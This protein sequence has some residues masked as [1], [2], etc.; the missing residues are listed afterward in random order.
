MSIN[1]G[2]RM[3]KW[4]IVLVIGMLSSVLVVMPM[5]NPYQPT[6]EYELITDVSDIKNKAEKIVFEFWNKPNT[7]KPFF[8]RIGDHDGWFGDGEWIEVGLD[9]RV[10][11]EK[12]V[13]KLAI[14]DQSEPG[15]ASAED[16]DMYLF[17]KVNKVYV[18]MHKNTSNEIEFGPQTGA[19]R[20]FGQKVKGAQYIPGAGYFQATES[21][22]PLQDNI[23]KKDI[24]F[25]PYIHALWG[26]DVSPFLVKIRKF[27]Y[28]LGRNVVDDILNN[29]DYTKIAAKV[30]SRRGNFLKLEQFNFIQT[31]LT[32][33]LEKIDI[34]THIFGLNDLRQIAFEFNNRQGW[35]L[36]HEI[37][38]WKAV[39]PVNYVLFGGG[40]SS[41]QEEPKNKV[42]LT[43]KEILLIVIS[44]IF[45]SLKLSIPN[46]VRKEELYL[47]DM[48]G[49]IPGWEMVTR[50]NM[51]NIVSAELDSFF[52]SDEYWDTVATWQDDQ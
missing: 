11:S 51:L 48:W 44:R 21:K 17:G 41:E 46:S 25:L 8:I 23:T 32:N 27:I 12:P 19:T 24:V 30:A 15:A 36:L 13:T 52:S 34:D 1:G 18:R 49:Q 6:E 28:T 14:T 40:V 16:V 22:L 39:K 2:R 7:E 3:K 20:V 50:G 33:Y 37:N 43:K 10:I 45:D 26:D 29:P 47:K 31:Y 5:D 9:H 35:T 38:M 4:F 42:E